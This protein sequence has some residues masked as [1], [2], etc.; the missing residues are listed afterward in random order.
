MFPSPSKTVASNR[1]P[2]RCLGENSSCTYPLAHS[3]L[4]RG[5]PFF[6]DEQQSPP[7]VHLSLSPVSVVVIPFSASQSQSNYGSRYVVVPMFSVHPRSHHSLD[8]SR[9]VES[10]F[11]LPSSLAPLP[12][13]TNTHRLSLPSST[14][15]LA[16]T[17]KS[18]FLMSKGRES[19]PFLRPRQALHGTPAGSSLS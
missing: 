9:T 7:S 1:G 16:P 5:F 18:N 6:L 12:A 10:P 17:T 14:I 3:S 19:L 13:T 11:P 15:L 8:H 4:N 2:A